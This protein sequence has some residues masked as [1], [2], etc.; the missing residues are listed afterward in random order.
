MSGP[1]VAELRGVVVR[2]GG[3][4]Y[5]PVLQGCSFSVDPGEK[6]V[7]VG[8]SGAGKTT[9]LRAIAGLHTIEE[10]TLRAP[11][12][13]GWLPQHPL[14]AFDPRWPVIRS[15]C[16]PLILA[17]EK[18]ADARVK[19]TRLLESVKLSRTQW[20]MRPLALSGGQL[21]RAAIARAIAASPSLVL[22]DE[23]TAG[24]D[25]EATLSLVDLFRQMTSERGTAVLWVTHDLGVASAVADR[26]I[27]LA[28]GKIVE[29]A[30]MDRLVV[31]PQT[32]AARRLVDAW[33]PLDPVAARQ[34]F[35][36]PGSVSPNPAAW[37]RSDP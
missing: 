15:V 12:S 24:L 26:V 32:E 31:N 28:E 4:G 11:E 25:P 10:G 33:L 20:D 21:R 23:P 30:T 13:I 17:G 3:D 7:I 5:P 22:A 2:P 37:I 8:E 19:A 34:Q 18:R 29:V 36:E 14:T 27:V 35:K 1:A 9:I 6:V 16:E